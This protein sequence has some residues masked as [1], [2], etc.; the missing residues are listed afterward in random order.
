MTHSF[1]TVSY[2]VEAGFLELQARSVARYLP[3]EMVDRI[4]VIYNSPTVMSGEKQKGLLRAYGPFSGQVDILHH[5]DV[6]A[7]PDVH[8]WRSQ[9]ILK[10]EIARQI[11]SK[12]YVALDAKNHLVYPLTPGFLTSGDGRARSS[13]SSFEN[14]QLRRHL[15]RALGYVGLDPK[16]YIERFPATVTPFTFETSVVRTLMNEV[17]AKAGRS[18]G[19]EFAGNMLTEFFLYNAY[20]LK[21]GN[22]KILQKDDRPMCLIIWANTAN[23]LNI[24]LAVGKTIERNTPF[25]AVHRNAIPLLQPAAQFKLANFYVRRSLFTAEEDALEFLRHISPPPLV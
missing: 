2:D 16:P 21:T 4:I 20:L 25:F 12:R 24:E 3:P 19:N 18:F 13:A 8:G 5:S 15:E 10:M 6:C 9:Q 23:E 7:L 22:L 11:E 1:V 17:E 14:H